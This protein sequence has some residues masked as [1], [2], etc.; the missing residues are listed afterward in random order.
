MKSC[1]KSCLLSHLISYSLNR[2][3]NRWKTKTKQKASL[4][5]RAAFSK[6]SNRGIPHNNPLEKAAAASKATPQLAQLHPSTPSV[7]P[8]SP[9]SPVPPLER[10]RERSRADRRTSNQR[11]QG[12]RKAEIAALKA[13]T[14]RTNTHPNPFS[15]SQSDKD[16]L[17]CP[18]GDRSPSTDSALHSQK[19]P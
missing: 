19:L 17:G 3:L 18:H 10:E 8:V 2:L 1:L 14:L 5:N 15:D 7:S 6:R 16:G 13:A 12:V 11:F 4:E 9:V